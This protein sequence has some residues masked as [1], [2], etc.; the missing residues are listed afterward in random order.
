MSRLWCSF[1]KNTRRDFTPSEKSRVCSAHFNPDCFDVNETKNAILVSMGQK[2]MPLSLKNDAVPTVKTDTPKSPTP[3]ASPS[4]TC[5]P[6]RGAFL[7]RAHQDALKNALDMTPWTPVAV[8]AKIQRTTTPSPCHYIPDCPSKEAAS[9]AQVT[10]KCANTQ[11]QLLLT[12]V[13][14]VQTTKVNLRNAGVQTLP[15]AKPS[16]VSRLT[17]NYYEDLMAGLAYLLMH[18]EEARLI[19]KS[20]DGPRPLSMEEQFHDKQEVF[21]LRQQRARFGNVE[22]PGE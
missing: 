6:K 18:W 2:P 12:R 7:K 1:V 8:K 9:Q 17:F 16:T 10:T 15:E 13:N 19:V 4:N 5:T 3:C 22:D 14:Q 11:V 20:F 21:D